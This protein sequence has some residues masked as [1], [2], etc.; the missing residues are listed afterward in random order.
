MESQCLLDQSILK[1][2][3]HSD[4]VGF[5]NE[6]KTTINL[7]SPS[8]SYLECVIPKSNTKDY[9]ECTLAISKF[10]LISKNTIEM[11][12]NIPPI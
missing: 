1:I 7:S 12:D 11:P 3:I 2:L 6:E 8:P 9:I 4:M 5:N 10:P